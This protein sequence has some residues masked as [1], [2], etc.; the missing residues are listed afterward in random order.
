MKALLSIFAN[1][2]RTLAKLF[3][4]NLCRVYT[5][6]EVFFFQQE[7]TEQPFQDDCKVNKLSKEYLFLLTLVIY[8]SKTKGIRFYGPMNTH[9]LS[10]IKVDQHQGPQTERS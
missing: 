3:H 10:P 7:E 5:N 9:T 4:P 2:L 1:E 8:Y 6:L